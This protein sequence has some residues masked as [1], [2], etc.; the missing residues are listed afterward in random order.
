MNYYKIQ[1]IATT[2]AT[3]AAAI[4]TNV[5]TVAD[6]VQKGATAALTVVNK[7]L[8]ATLLKSPMMLVIGVLAAG[9]FYLLQWAE[10]TGFLKTAFDRTITLIVDGI[11]WVIGLINKIPG[12]EITAVEHVVTDTSGMEETPDPAADTLSLSSGSAQTQSY[13]ADLDA[14]SYDYAGISQ[15][16]EQPDYLATAYEVDYSYPA[17]Y[18]QPDYLATAYDVDYSYPAAQSYQLDPEPLV[19]SQ[20]EVVKEIEGA[21]AISPQLLEA[22]HAPVYN[23]TSS[24]EENTTNNWTVSPTL[25]VNAQVNQEMD[26]EKMA[27]RLGMYLDEQMSAYSHRPNMR[28][29]VISL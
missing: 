24:H 3:K 8:N 20:V 29:G 27:K 4:I 7:A 15:A 23:Q 5:K 19:V 10:S 25:V 14:G 22:L 18:E 11:N 13:L 26:V 6:T 12:I 2:I 28:R 21:V 16:Y 1:L 9:V 17:T